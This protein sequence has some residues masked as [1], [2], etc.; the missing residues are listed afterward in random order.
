MLLCFVV[1]PLPNWLVLPGIAELFSFVLFCC[2]ASFCCIVLHDFIVSFYLIF[3]FC[4]ILFC[5]A[6]LFYI[7]IPCL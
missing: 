3:L 2:S 1:P 5:F 7:L 6:L 4:S